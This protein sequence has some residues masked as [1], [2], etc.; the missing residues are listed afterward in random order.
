MGVCL[1]IYT[2][3]KISCRTKYPYNDKETSLGCPTIDRAHFT[4]ISLLVHL[5]IKHESRFASDVVSQM[6]QRTCERQ[7]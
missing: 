7:G 5:L 4:F 1:T 6:Y 3:S 2:V